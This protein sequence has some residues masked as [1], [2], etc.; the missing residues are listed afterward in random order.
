MKKVISLVLLVAMLVSSV[1][2][3]AN[4]ITD[5][6]QEILASVKE[7]IGNTERFD[8][9]NSASW[10]SDGFKVYEFSWEMKDGNDYI[11]ISATE[12]GVITNYYRYHKR[13]ADDRITLSKISSDEAL[14]KAQEMVDALNPDLKGKIVVEKVDNT[15]NLYSREFRFNVQRYENGYKVKGNSG[16]VRIN[17]EVDKIISFYLNYTDNITFE[18]PKTVLT[19]DEASSFFASKLGM[20]LQYMSEYDYQKAD[21]SVYLAYVPENTKTVY[22]DA[23]TGEVKELIIGGGYY[24][25]NDTVTEESATDLAGGGANYK[26]SEAEQKNIDELGMLLTESEIK[27]KLSENKNIRIL[28]TDNVRVNLNLDRYS[29][30]YYYNLNYETEKAHC[31]VKVDAATGAILNYSYY[32]YTDEKTTAKELPKDVLSQKKE[33]VIKALSGKRF[34]EYKKEEDDDIYTR[35]VNGIPYVD[36]VISAELDA[37]TGELVRYRISYT[38]Y[39]PFPNPD[40]VISAYDAG[41][42]LAGSA[43]Y[44]PCYIIS[45]KD[46]NSIFDNM[47][48]LV[49]D[50]DSKYTLKIDAFSGKLLDYGSEEY[51]DKKK[52]EYKDISGHYAEDK[53]KELAKYGIGFS[54]ENF[55]P[56]DAILQKEYI[57]LLVSVFLYNGVEPVNDDNTD[58]FYEE[59]MYRGIIK[60]D[61]V[62]KESEVTRFDAVKYFVRAIGAEK[63]ATLSGIYVSP[64]ADV[65]ENIGYTALLY[66][67]G[68]INGDEDGNFNGESILTR[69]DSIIIIHN[70]LS[71]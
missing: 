57:S 55:R 14:I 11:N 60:E 43:E 28:K 3:F 59:A 36:D 16:S 67:M 53:I 13:E 66:G 21:K 25:Y 63:Y 19:K 5:K 61:E 20:K 34:E 8:E 56:D 54:G 29:K 70:Y 37:Y 30:Q 51:E 69:A 50:F 22:I 35:Y 9:F 26:F 23:E 47:S 32:D 49:Y 65:T 40:G 27:A 42:N 44:E 41:V 58:T 62:S 31:S 6:T 68:I 10:D 7:R 33:A 18:A 52:L 17:E 48:T 12:S 71:K 45:K 64:F 15:E 39:V 4:S 38:D 1:S 46:E 24:L 2:V